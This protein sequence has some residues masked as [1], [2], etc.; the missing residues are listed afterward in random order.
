[1]E[2]FEEILEQVRRPARYLGNEWNVVKKDVSAAEVKIAL[3]FPDAYEV[4][5]SHLGFRIIYGILNDRTDTVCERVFTPWPDFSAQLEKRD[6]PLFTLESKTP[7]DKF[8]IVA[9]TLSYEMNYTNILEIL[10][11]GRIPLTSVQ[12]G[13]EHPIIIGG[14]PCALNP[15]PLADFFDLF[16]VGD[17]ETVTNELVD[18]YRRLK[19][20]NIKDKTKVLAELSKIEGVYVPLLY[21][22]PRTIKKRVVDDLD[23]SFYPTRY[24]V[25]YMSIIHDRVV[26]EIM[27]GCVHKCRFCQANMCYRPVR[28][29]SKEKILDLIKASYNNTGYEEFSLMSL[30]SG[31]YPNITGLIEEFSNLDVL[32]EKGVSISLPSLRVEDVL[33]ELPASVKKV[34]K[35]GLTFAP[36]AGTERLRKV[37]S[38]EID[39]KKLLEA[40]NVAQREGWRRV[41]LYFMIGLPTE[42][43][44]DIDG[45]LDLL[46]QISSLT[47]RGV[48]E[49]AV[50]ISPFIP[51]A[52][53][54]FQWEKMEGRKGLL[55]KQEYMRTRT[56]SRRIRLKFHKFNLSFMEAVFSR[57]DRRLG[58]VLLSAFEKGAR[59]DSWDEFF[60]FDIWMEAFDKEGIDPLFYTGPRNFDDKLPWDHIDIGI[61]K[62]WLIKEAKEAHSHYI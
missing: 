61:S 31:N 17:G 19:S 43:Y 7:L 58:R 23:K 36:E 62:E 5:M 47:G 13:P 48:F 32:K 46:H 57:G 35:T 29:R 27:R 54:P 38:K 45:M 50:S 12:R 51:K 30:S 42:D 39:T 56:K 53:T 55:E 18:A 49:I 3:C 14:G 33:K 4:G 59:F 1:M 21:K 52:H 26:V 22:A 9:F 34:K 44:S 15:E 60:N 10:K 41:K 2:H 28:T 11:L 16:V 24:L 40:I 25:P 8:D 37:I 6:L 20:E